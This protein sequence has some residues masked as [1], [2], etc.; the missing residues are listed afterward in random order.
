MNTPELN[1]DAPSF[2]PKHDSHI[3]CKGSQREASGRPSPPRQAEVASWVLENRRSVI[4]GSTERDLRKFIQG[5]LD[6]VPVQLLREF[7]HLVP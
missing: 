5:D 1:P 2:T 7:D 6:Y 4:S 3:H